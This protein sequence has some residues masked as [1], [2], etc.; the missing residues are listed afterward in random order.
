MEWDT[1]TSTFMNSEKYINVVWYKYNGNL[2]DGLLSSLTGQEWN[3]T[4]Y[5]DAL[6]ITVTYDLHDNEINNKSES[7]DVTEWVLDNQSEY[8]HTYNGTDQLTQTIIRNRYNIDSAYTNSQKMV[9]SN[10][11]SYTNIQNQTA[12]NQLGVTI[13]PNPLN[14]SSTINIEQ[15]TLGTQFKLYDILGHEV[16]TTL[17]ETPHTT[18]EKGDL[19]KGIYIYQIL[20]ENQSLAKGKLIIQ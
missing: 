10:F 4:S 16:Y 2:D 14:S 19:Q 17:L 5:V 18:I 7:W 11:I 8:L 6:K 12:D 3:G 9:F 20:N 13:Y 1:I 15:N